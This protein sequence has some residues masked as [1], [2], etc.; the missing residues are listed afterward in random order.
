MIRSKSM[1]INESE[2]KYIS[3]EIN[4]RPSTEIGVPLSVYSNSSDIL[5]SINEDYPSI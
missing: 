1:P 3:Y 4:G 2:K 5:N